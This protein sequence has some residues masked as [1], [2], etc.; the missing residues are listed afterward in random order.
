MHMSG[1]P[2]AYGKGGGGVSQMQSLQAEIIQAATQLAKNPVAAQ[3]V[4]Q[5]LRLAAQDPYTLP[6]AARGQPVIRQGPMP[7]A[8][9]MVARG[10]AP[11]AGGAMASSNLDVLKAQKM[12]NKVNA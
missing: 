5:V 12:C 4:L 8:N 6:A 3:Q 9:A 7:V 2:A 10:P 11:V 1:P